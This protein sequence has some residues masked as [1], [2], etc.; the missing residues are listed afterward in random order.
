[1]TLLIKTDSLNLNK[2]I[3]PPWGGE[4]ENNI[5]FYLLLVVPA[6]VPLRL[7]VSSCPPPV[8][9]WVVLP[10]DSRG[11]FPLSMV[12]VDAALFVGAVLVAGVVF[13]VGST[14]PAVVMGTDVVFVLLAAFPS[15]QP[16]RAAT[17]SISTRT[18]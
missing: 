15:R 12:G 11:P 16:A 8:E 1:M 7:R 14:V 6:P 2:M 9:F 4:K 5:R 13:S 10:V 18:G 17:M 3:S